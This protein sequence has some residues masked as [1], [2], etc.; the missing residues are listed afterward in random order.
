[1]LWRRGGQIREEARDARRNRLVPSSL[2]GRLVG[3]TGKSEE[4]DAAPCRV[5][6]RDTEQA[7]ATPVGEWTWAG[8]G[9]M[10][11][12][13]R[14]LG[15]RAVPHTWNIQYILEIF[16]KIRQCFTGNQF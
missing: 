16:R 13:T 15:S 12:N 14:H 3:E 4:K 6:L 5:E 7:H 2:Y 8:V 10:S 1:M 11:A 9:G